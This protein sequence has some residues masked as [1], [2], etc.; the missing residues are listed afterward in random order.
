MI[1]YEILNEFTYTILAKSNNI[2]ETDAKSFSMKIYSFSKD[3][4]VLCQ[5]TAISD[6]LTLWDLAKIVFLN[7]FEIS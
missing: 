7:S 2:N 4:L 1:G 3:S 6:L 5:K